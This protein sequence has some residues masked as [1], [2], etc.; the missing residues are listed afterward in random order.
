MSA[1]ARPIL[2]NAQMVRA[3][4]DGRKTQTRRVLKPQPTL[5][6]RMWSWASRTLLVA[7]WSDGASVAPGVLSHCPY[8]RVGDLL[9]VRETFAMENCREVGPYP[10]PH[11][12]GRPSREHEDSEDGGWWEQPHYRATDETPCLAYE[13]GH[14]GC[15]WRPSIFMPRWA[16]R[17]TLRITDVRVERLQDITEEDAYA[18]GIT[19]AQAMEFND[20]GSPDPVLAFFDLWNEINGVAASDANPWVWAVSFEVIH[21]NVD[22]VL[23]AEA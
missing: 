11:S 21:K 15:R 18:E 10:K 19:D 17:L 5:A 13:D 4:L 20:D 9:W 1:K 3:L 23:E 7:S 6:Q 14:E 12:D 2:F 16:S 8:G 22:Q